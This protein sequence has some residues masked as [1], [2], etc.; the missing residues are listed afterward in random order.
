MASA[1]GMLGPK[2]S[3][4]QSGN[5]DQSG[6]SAVNALQRKVTMNPL[7][8]YG[9]SYTPPTVRRCWTPQDSCEGQPSVP[10]DSSPGPNATIGM[11]AI[12]RRRSPSVP[13][14]ALPIDLSRRAADFAW[15]CS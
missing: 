4:V 7:S 14:Y 12:I 3:A 15:A 2:F 1:W 11:S 5:A 6:V 8:T 9:A 10:S 13:S